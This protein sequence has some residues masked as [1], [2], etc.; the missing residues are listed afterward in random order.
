MSQINK[1]P[2]FIEKL[3]SVI[4][5]QQE[6]SERIFDKL[7]DDAVRNERMREA[8]VR[9]P[10]AAD[11]QTDA[12]EELSERI[13]EAAEA[14]SKMA[15]GFEKF[16]ETLE[17]FDATTAGQTESILQMSKTFSASDRYLKYLITQQNKRFMWI[18]FTAIGVCSVVILLFVLM[19]IY[20]R[21]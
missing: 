1:F 18:F 13:S 8:M 6:L 11:K 20:L 4:R 5:N 16:N 17:H 9:I 14:D 12:I 19:V 7:K 21:Q 10:E 3:P 15:G 2:D